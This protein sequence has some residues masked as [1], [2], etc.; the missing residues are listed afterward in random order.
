[1]GDLQSY[2]GTRTV[3]YYT[4]TDRYIIT[5]FSHEGLFLLHV[6]QGN[7]RRNVQLH[8]LQDILKIPQVPNSVQITRTYKG[9]DF[10]PPEA[11]ILIRM[12][13]VLREDYLIPDIEPVLADISHNVAVFP[14]RV[15]TKLMI[16]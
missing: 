6:V 1:M 5:T 12:A 15:G 13:S 4:G 8:Y 3:K 7:P 14:Q 2:V 11:S 16:W 10:T 9:A